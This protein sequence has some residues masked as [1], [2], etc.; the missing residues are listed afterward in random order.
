MT[1]T[2]AR[3][4]CLYAETIDEARGDTPMG[5]LFTDLDD[6]PELEADPDLCWFLGC[7]QGAADALGLLPEQL[8]ERARKCVG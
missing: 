7:I 4:I 8:I 2:L 1:P 6:Y 3:S 5:R